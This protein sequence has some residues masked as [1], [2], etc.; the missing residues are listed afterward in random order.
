MRAGNNGSWSA[1]L[2]I[3]G[4]WIAVEAQAQDRGQP[5]P[6]GRQVGPISFEAMLQRCDKNGDGKVTEEEFLG[7]RQLF[8]RVD[9]NGDGTVTRDEFDAARRQAVGVGRGNASK[10]SA[11]NAAKQESPGP[12]PEGVELLTDLAYRDG[13]EK[14]QLDLAMPKEPGDRPRPALVIIHGGGWRSGDKG[15]GQWRALPLEY[16]AKGYVA[17]SV[18]YRFIDEAAFSA[19]VEDVKCAVRWLRANAK[20]YNVDPRRIGA[21][22]NSAGAHLVAMLGLAGPEAGLEGD[23][24]Y[25]DQ[26]SLVQAV[27]CSAT[28]TDF[29]DWPGRSPRAESAFLAGPGESVAER[30]KKLSP[31]SYVRA[32]APPM[33]VIHGT[34]DKTVPLSQ[35]EKFV[36]ALKKAGAKD[37]TFL[38]YDGAGHGVFIQQADETGPAME[39]F[40][41]RTLQ[42]NLP[43]E[44]DSRQ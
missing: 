13:N 41:A 8:T 20:K 37:V 6:A 22:G 30:M 3:L 27:C 39:A 42:G 21:Y 32:D 29:V 19:C 35:G 11:P 10:R 43:A 24:P 5:G 23:G 38:K 33:L 2:L 44:K 28:P 7:P 31:I 18:N 9:R 26:S 25:R 12:I 17:V 4:T 36:E 40:F 15:G 14:W 1:A 34:A 16:A